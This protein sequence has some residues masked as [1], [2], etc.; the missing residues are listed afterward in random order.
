MKTFKA[1][2]W[3]VVLV[4]SLHMLSGCYGRFQVTQ[5]IHSWNGRVGSQWQQEGLFFLIFPVYAF[6]M[7]SDALVFNAIEFWTG[8]N[9]IIDVPGDEEYTRSIPAGNRRVVI[10]RPASEPG[11]HVTL[12][13]FEGAVLL[14]EYS[15]EERDGSVSV[16]RDAGGAVLGRVR[17]LPDGSVEFESHRGSRRVRYSRDQL[18]T[19]VKCP[20]PFPDRPHF[21]IWRYGVVK[22]DG[23]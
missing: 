5:H 15:I 3:F 19:L 21:R 17:A 23:S 4:L 20:A 14:A 11:R 1:F 9:P 18:A 12:K 6:T 22:S 10:H 13:M 8:I 16:V 7:V 2:S